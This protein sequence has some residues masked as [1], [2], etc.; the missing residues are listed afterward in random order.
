[1][2]QATCSICLEELVNEECRVVEVKTHDL[3][4]LFCRSGVRGARGEHDS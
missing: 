1:M 2:L 3:N 4:A